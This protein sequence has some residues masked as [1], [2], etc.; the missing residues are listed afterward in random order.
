MANISAGLLMYRHNQ[1]GLLEVFLLHPGGPFYLKKD[2]GHWS[3]PKGEVENKD[4]EKFLEDAKREF[5]EETDNEPPKG[6]HFSNLGNVKLKSGKTIYAWAFEGSLNQPFASNKFKMEWPPK[7]GKF[8]EYPEC[9]RAEWFT[10]EKAKEKINHAQSVFID[11]LV[12]Q[13]NQL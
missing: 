1:E 6:T 8:Q 13:L 10:V 3:I 12:D 9:D 7:S 4:T 5:K 2:E 11:R